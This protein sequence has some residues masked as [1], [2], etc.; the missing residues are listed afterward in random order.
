MYRHHCLL[1]YSHENIVSSASSPTRPDE[2]NLYAG[3]TEFTFVLIFA[4]VI[5]KICFIYCKKKLLSNQH[6][7]SCHSVLLQQVCS[8]L[9]LSEQSQAPYRCQSARYNQIHR[10][11]P[12]FLQ[13]RYT[14]RQHRH[15]SCFQRLHRFISTFWASFMVRVPFTYVM[16]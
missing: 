13:C 4:A 7:L 16:S 1:L 6:I 5:V 3:T 11:S 8:C 10:H 14:E 9:R 15:M 2:V 12:H